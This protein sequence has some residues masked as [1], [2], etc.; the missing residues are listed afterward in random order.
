MPR[1]AQQRASSPAEL[2]LLADEESLRQAG[3]TV[4]GWDN[5][6][7]AP[8]ANTIEL[9][10]KVLRTLFG[11]KAHRTADAVICGR[12]YEK[13]STG[14]AVDIRLQPVS[15]YRDL[16]YIDTKTTDE[17][18]LVKEVRALHPLSRKSTTVPFS[19]L[20]VLPVDGSWLPLFALR[21][22]ILLFKSFLDER[23]AIPPDRVLKAAKAGAKVPNLA[24]QLIVLR[25][26]PDN[27]VFYRHQLTGEVRVFNYGRMEAQGVI[28][29]D[30]P[31]WVLTWAHDYRPL[32][33]RQKNTT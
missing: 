9:S 20:L 1:F 5:L 26:C 8:S 24:Q 31:N 27:R 6:T 22:P 33:K 32:R 15:L 17:P 2:K 19:R 10:V 14:M 18:L 29:K 7:Q 30:D 23:V 28:S 13:R 12:S 11:M 3:F 25:A 21:R 4:Y 16:P